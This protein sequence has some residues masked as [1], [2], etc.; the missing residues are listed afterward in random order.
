MPIHINR[1]EALSWVQLTTLCKM[2]GASSVKP[3]AQLVEELRTYLTSNP[4]AV[5][6]DGVLIPGNKKS[7]NS[8][9]S[10]KTL[11]KPMYLNR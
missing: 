5:T 8:N 10:K 11:S 2:F 1:L 7:L 3:K 9:S 6:E 4:F